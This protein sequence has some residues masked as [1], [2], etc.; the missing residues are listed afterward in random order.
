[1]GLENNYIPVVKRLSNKSFEIVDLHI[2]EVVYSSIESG[3]ITYVTFDGQTFYQINTIEEQERYLDRFGFRKVERGYI[4]HMEKVKGFNEDR[5]VLYF[6]KPFNQ[7][8][9]LAPVSRPH[10]VALRQEGII[11]TGGLIARQGGLSTST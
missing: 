8:A 2:E 4:V 3:V 10:E 9:P 5:H 1:L 7:K 6:H 11:G